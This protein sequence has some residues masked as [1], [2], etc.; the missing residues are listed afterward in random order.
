M[1]ASGEMKDLPA[2]ESVLSDAPIAPQGGHSPRLVPPHT[3]LHGMLLWFITL[4][5]IVLTSAAVGAGA[6]VWGGS[7]DA[8]RQTSWVLTSTVITQGVVGG[9]TAAWLLRWQIPRG[10][11]LPLRI[12]TPS[13]WVGG[14]LVTLGLA[15]L[16]TAIAL[17]VQRW[18]PAEFSALE[19]ARRLA[20]AQGATWVVVLLCVCLLPAIV[21]EALFRGVLTEAFA[22]HSVWLGALVPSL[23][24]GIF[25]FDLAQSAGTA[26]LGLGFAAAR[27]YTGSMLAPAV[28][29]GLNNL[30]ALLSTRYASDPM[31]PVPITTVLG[32][33]VLAL[34]GL[35][36]LRRDAKR[37]Q[38]S[39]V[40]GQ[41]CKS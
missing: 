4:L 12:P 19:M 1:L 33:L 18:A 40:T 14:I 3:P 13:G 28:A 32:A 5:G 31:A 20:T 29:H 30:L 34:V 15:P 10:V 26:V 23:L 38:T 27:L 11:A 22:R 36:L 24:F 39:Q 21:E 35:A 16:A 6:V 17:Y 8:L 7:V 37:R 9:I 41:A 2:A 25:H